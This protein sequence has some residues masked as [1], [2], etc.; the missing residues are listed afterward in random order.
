MSAIAFHELRYRAG[1]R[2]VS[3]NLVAELGRVLSLFTVMPFDNAAAIAA[4]RVRLDL[5]R[6]GRP[7]GIMDTLQAGH[8]LA[9]GGVFVTDDSDFR[10]VAGLTVENW[11]R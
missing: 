5:E 8:A 9:S 10:R 4:V 11:R 2:G 3:R 7:I 6:I 1:R